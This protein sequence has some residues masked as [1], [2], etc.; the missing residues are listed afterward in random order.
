MAALLIHTCT[1]RI[2]D[3]DI[4][5]ELIPIEIEKSGLLPVGTR[6][7]RGPDWDPDRYGD[8][9]S[10]CVGT[11]VCQSEDGLYNHT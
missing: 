11:V 9:D 4:L 6:V 10:Q 3:A 1:T 2:I 5:E 8:Q 7:T